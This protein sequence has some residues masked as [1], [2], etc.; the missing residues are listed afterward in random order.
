M[1]LADSVLPAES[2]SP[3]TTLPCPASWTRIEAVP[4]HS[5]GVQIPPPRPAFLPLREKSTARIGRYH[6]TPLRF[7]SLRTF[8]SL[9]VHFSPLRRAPQFL[10]N[11]IKLCALRVKTRRR[12]AALRQVPARPAFKAERSRR[13]PASSRNHYRLDPRAVRS[14]KATPE[15][16]ELAANSEIVRGPCTCSQLNHALAQTLLRCILCLAC[17]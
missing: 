17:S 16:G 4:L 2:V 7:H 11:P 10:H 15:A 5:R 13:Q 8:P 6:G 14:T 12:L 9:L 1:A 3:T